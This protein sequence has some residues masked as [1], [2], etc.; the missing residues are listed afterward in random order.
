MMCGVPT[1]ASVENWLLSGCAI[2]AV[3]VGLLKLRM[4][5]LG[6]DPVYEVIASSLSSL[7]SSSEEISP[8]LSGSG[9]KRLSFCETAL[10]FGL[11]DKG[12]AYSHGDVSI[13]RA[14][15]GKSPCNNRR[16]GS[17]EHSYKP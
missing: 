3:D 14:S 10:N 7:S 16:R 4:G 12:A 6:A 11:F 8:S 9:S 13:A 2:V 1:C 17:E 15:A 5:L